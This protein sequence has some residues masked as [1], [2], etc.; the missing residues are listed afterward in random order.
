MPFIFFREHQII[1]VLLL[2]RNTYRA[3]QLKRKVHLSKTVCGIFHFWFRLVFIKVYIFVF[4]FNKSIDSLTLKRD[5][6]FQNLN[7]RKVTHSFAP[8]P[9]IFKL[10]QEVWKFNDVYMS[11]SS[12]KIDLQTNFSN[13]ENR[14]VEYVTFP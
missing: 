8:R 14:N 13:L 7:N 2:I 10:Q 6:S 3:Y 12:S 11:W 4:L 1:T 5:N 9:L